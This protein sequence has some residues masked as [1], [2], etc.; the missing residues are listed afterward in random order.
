MKTI[1]I[2]IL[3]CITFGTY[4]QDPKL[5]SNEWFLEKLVIN[6][7][8][9]F[10]PNKNLIGNIVFTQTGV[11]VGHEFCEDFRSTSIIGYQS[12]MSFTITDG[13]T[14]LDGVC[15]QPDRIEFMENHYSIYLTQDEV[16]KNPFSYEIIT[17]NDVTSLVVTNVD[18]DQAFYNN[19][20]TLSVKDINKLVIS[21]YPNPVQDQLLINSKRKLTTANIYSITGKLVAEHTLSHT[22]VINTSELS[23]GLYFI[24]V[25]GMDGNKTTKR[26]VKK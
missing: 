17:D 5:L 6:N 9:I 1:Y 20:P 10:T 3:S 12:D 4:A 7:T 23:K 22:A 16:A 15:G 25:E 14:R 18:G 11:G 2:L 19:T 21:L 8:D 26:F 13:W 24:T